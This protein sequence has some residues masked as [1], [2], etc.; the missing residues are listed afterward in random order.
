MK[1]STNPMA[2]PSPAKRRKINLSGNYYLAILALA[3]SGLLISL[4]RTGFV[5]LARQPRH[6]GGDVS[7]SPPALYPPKT[8]ADHLALARRLLEIN[9]TRRALEEI[10]IARSL[11]A[12]AQDS[13]NILEA[14]RRQAKIRELFLEDYRRWTK[15]V[16]TRPGYR[17]GWY[18]LAVLAWMLGKD[19]QAVHAAGQVL[20]LDPNF[21]PGKE[22]LEL[23]KQK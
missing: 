4:F 10:Q 16:A 21:R 6:V 20:S 3:A 1:S 13:E 12:S 5:L 18:Q 17:D 11:G 2:K 14:A 15:T 19:S 9:Q 23:V 7:L 8:A 22:L